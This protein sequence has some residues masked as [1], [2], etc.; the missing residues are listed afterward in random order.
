MG[1]KT[2]HQTVKFL[3]LQ[4]AS[5]ILLEKNIA[6]QTDMMILFSLCEYH[7]YLWIEYCGSTPTN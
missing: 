2:I 6:Q 4:V 7:G 3:A 5:L 1:Q